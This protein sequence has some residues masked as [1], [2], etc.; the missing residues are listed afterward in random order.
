MSQRNVV[1]AN[2]FTLFQSLHEFKLAGAEG[3]TADMTFSG[4]GAV[5]GNVD[6]GGDVIVKGAFA[7]SLKEFK[8][9]GIWPS[10]LSQH[11][12]WGFTAQDLTP[13]GV[14]TS[15]EEDDVGLKVEGKL[16]N[17]MRGT[18]LY[19]LMKM[20]PRPAIS[21]MSIGYTAA[22]ED[23]IIGKKLGD[24]AR[25]LKRVTLRELSVV[26]FPMNLE[27]QVQSVKSD[28]LSIRVA[29]QALR[30]VGFSTTDAKTILAV[31]YKAIQQRDVVDIE[32]L[33][34]QIQKNIDSF[35]G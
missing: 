16:A 30:D 22:N 3:D 13:V 11:G 1:A 34:V 23:I 31:G 25:T 14:W 8:K 9:S 21:G 32:A 6:Q 24:P 35:I 2:V 4:Y 33:A 27:A 15:M 10:M 20:T 17:T 28:G 19:T 18:E 5:F 7:R 12:G 29:E 26:T